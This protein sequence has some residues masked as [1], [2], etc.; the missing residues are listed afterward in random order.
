MFNPAAVHEAAAISAKASL[1]S[2]ALSQRLSKHKAN[3]RSAKRSASR[4]STRGSREE[5][6]AYLS[7][8]PSGLGPDERRKGYNP[9]RRIAP[10]EQWPEE[11][12]RIMACRIRYGGNPE[13]K[14]RPGDYGLVPPA[15]PRPGKTLCDAEGEFPKARAE[16][17][18][19][20]GLL[21]GMASV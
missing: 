12:C 1:R 4:N 18:L 7:T 19:R 8:Q 21:R 20:A 2:S 13:H 15:N 11:K 3:G 16:E 9:K 17:L 14:C 6:L 10:A 5:A